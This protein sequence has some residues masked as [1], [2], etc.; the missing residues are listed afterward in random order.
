MEVGG[1]AGEEGGLGAKEK[2]GRGKGGR[3][4]AAAVSARSSACRRAD[5]AGKADR[6]SMLSV[7]R[8]SARRQAT[9]RTPTGR[10]VAVWWPFGGRLVAVRWPFGGP[11]VAV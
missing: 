11:L 8:D 10:S 7:M 9:R 3:A 6:P 2:L 5:S 4:E 1:E